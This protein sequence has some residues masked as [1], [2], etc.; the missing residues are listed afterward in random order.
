[1]LQQCLGNAFHEAG[2][3][4]MVAS[5]VTQVLVDRDDPA[6]R[7]P[8]KPVGEM[9][10]DE[11]V[12][13]LE[14]RGWTLR[15]DEKRGGSRRV[16]ASPEPIEIVEAGAI[17]V[18][19]RAGVVVVAA[20]GGGVPVISAGEGV[21]GTAA[22]VDKD[23]ASA[24]LAA[25]LGADALVILTDVEHVSRSYG[26]PDEQPIEELTVAEA[27]ALLEAGEFGEG[28]MKPKVEAMIRFV[29]RTEGIGVIASI[30][31]A[32]EALGGSGT[33]FIR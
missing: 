11:D 2:T 3:D 10:P 21:N 17:A 23:L 13:A 9:V 6:F 32:A 15:H 26:K 30:E 18:L 16:V 29:E 24:L 33:R 19:V 5:L 1:M 31:R 20:G 22:V 4:V 25:D 28:S 8:S 27:R 14:E 12:P 7:A